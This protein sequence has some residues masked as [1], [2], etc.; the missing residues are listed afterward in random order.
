MSGCLGRALRPLAAGCLPE[1]DALVLPAHTAAQL[2][3]L[4]GPLLLLL[5]LPLLPLLGSLPVAHRQTSLPLN[6]Q[7]LYSTAALPHYP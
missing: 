3:F 6:G 7:A 1:G 5:L 2:H 4:T